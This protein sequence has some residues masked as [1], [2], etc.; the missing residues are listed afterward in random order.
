MTFTLLHL[1]GMG[2]NF[3]ATGPSSHL[4]VA[5]ALSL[6]VGYLFW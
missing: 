6:G 5:P 2:F 3:I 1:A 4:I